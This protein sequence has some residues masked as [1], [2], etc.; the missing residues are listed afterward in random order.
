MRP[1]WWHVDKIPFKE[2]WPDDIHWM[3]LFLNG[4]KFRGK[5]LFGESDVIIK[6]ELSE[7]KEL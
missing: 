6:K 1:Q 7:V 5:F 3:P 4:R 2:M